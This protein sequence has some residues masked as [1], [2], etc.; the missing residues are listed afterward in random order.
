[1]PLY[2]ELANRLAGLI[3]QGTF[4]P[5]ERI[6]SVRQMSRQNGVSISTVLQAYLL[7]EDRGLI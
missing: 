7:L 5:G 3:E 2:E 4:R 1:M 6:P